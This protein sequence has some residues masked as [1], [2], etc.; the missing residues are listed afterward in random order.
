MSIDD[1]R[2]DLVDSIEQGDAA[3]VAVALKNGAVVDANCF[4][5]TIDNPRVSDV[6]VK[7]DIL[8]RLLPKLPLLDKTKDDLI[9]TA[10]V[11]GMPEIAA[12]L[13]QTFGR[14]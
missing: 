9:A 11:R 3:R 4:Y 13:K 12:F 2:I 8:S 6:K 14:N 5:A 10:E 7:I 1:A